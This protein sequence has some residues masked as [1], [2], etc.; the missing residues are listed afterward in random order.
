MS[1]ESGALSPYTDLIVCPHCDA[2]YS[3]KRP[4][5]GERA[6]C[7]RCHTVLITPRR[8]AGMQIISLSLAIVILI[9]AATVMPF[10]TISA[11]G[12]GN[13]VSIL[14]AALAFS[15]GL[16][17]VLSLA[18]A[19]LIIFIPLTR[20]LL[21]LYVL[22]PVVFDRPPAPHAKRAFRLAEKLRPWS[23]AE[24]F[25]IGCAVA[26]VKVVDLAEVTFG[27]AF[28]MFA[29]LVLL[30]VAQDAFMCRW[31]VWNSLDETENT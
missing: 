29:M 20:V 16:L 13:A 27:P 22:I 8:R 1:A 14:D 3:L 5:P 25:A 24:I 18:V 15:D 26:L 30:V 9:V 23:M 17:V 12:N 31:S 28:W 4:E 21:S 19:A 11:A 2:A 10:L 7:Q 6:V